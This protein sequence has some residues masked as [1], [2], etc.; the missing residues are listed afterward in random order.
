M[1]QQRKP[2]YTF[3]GLR[4]GIHLRVGMRIAILHLVGARVRKWAQE[5][6]VVLE[7]FME[8]EDVQI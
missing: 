5:F 1:S 2:V 8:Y 6:P 7:K 4:T 3:K